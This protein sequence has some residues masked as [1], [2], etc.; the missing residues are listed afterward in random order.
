MKILIIV[1]FIS[2]QSCSIKDY[3]GELTPGDLVIVNQKLVIKE[4]DARVSIQ[5]GRVQAY[6]RL[7]HYYPH[8]WFISIK[9]EATPQ[10]IQPATFKIVKIRQVYEYVMNSKGGYMLSAF[11]SSDGLTAVS[12]TTEINLYSEKQKN[13]TRL[14]CSHWEDPADA[15]HLTLAQIKQTLE[16]LVSISTG[17]SLM[18]TK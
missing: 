16:P 4:N 15:E 3:Y 7:N 14:L 17:S 12:Y 10:I 6:S 8:C 1:A 2:L 5:N 9:R 18:I 13:I 11:L